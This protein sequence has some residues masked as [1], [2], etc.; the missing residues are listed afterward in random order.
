M[1]KFTRTY[2]NG[3]DTLNGSIGLTP[4]DQPVKYRLHTP[5]EGEWLDSACRMGSG[6]GH[7]NWRQI[8]LIRPVTDAAGHGYGLDVAFA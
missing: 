5:S 1:N 7:T 3:E 8:D 4:A 2:T 6:S